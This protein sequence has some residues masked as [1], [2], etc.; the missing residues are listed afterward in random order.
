MKEMTPVTQ[1]L[2]GVTTIGIITALM[3]PDRQTAKVGGVLFSGVK[4]LFATVISGKG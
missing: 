4:G 2:A 1:L 3:L